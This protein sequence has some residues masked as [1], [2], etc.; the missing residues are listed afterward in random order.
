[1]RNE[2]DF[3]YLDDETLSKIENE[4]ERI[5]QLIEKRKGM[6]L[7]NRDMSKRGFMCELVAR[8]LLG[9][10]LTLNDELDAGFDIC[11]NGKGCLHSKINEA[12]YGVMQDNGQLTNGIDYSILEELCRVMKYIYIY[13]VQ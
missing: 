9:L 10:P 8:L 11:Y 1:M 4:A 3:I 2:N 13:L 6:N 12:L 5:M 7:S